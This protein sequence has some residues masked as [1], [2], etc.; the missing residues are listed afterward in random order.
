MA[1]LHRQMIYELSQRFHF[2]AAHTL[3][4]P[5]DNQAEL[6]ASQRVHGHTYFAEVALHGQPDHST[7]MLIDI[8]KFRQMLADVAALLDH[9]L[10]D[11]VPGLSKPTLEGLCA[12]IAHKLEQRLAGLAS[13][14]VWREPSGDRCKLICQEP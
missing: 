3:I 13:V 14:T 1:D 2:D 9:R 6:E 8:G 7:G 11:H 10:L 5:T 4:R 12:F